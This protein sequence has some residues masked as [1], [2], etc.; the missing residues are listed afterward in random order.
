[1][2]SAIPKSQSKKPAQTR[3]DNIFFHPKRR[4]FLVTKNFTPG[5]SIFGEALLRIGKEEYREWD[6]SRSKLAAGIMNRISQIAVRQGSKVLYLG[7]SHGYT[8]S[9]VSDIVGKEGFVF[10]VE[11][12]PTVAKQLVR[13]CRLRENMAPL[14]E[15]ANHPER[16]A[17]RVVV[18]DVLYQ[19]VAQRNQVEIFRKNLSL[20]IREGGFG[21]LAVK[22]R[23][24]DVTKKPRAV[25]AEVARQLEAF[26]TVVDWRTL[27][28]FEK[29]H[30]L[31]VCKRR[32]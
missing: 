19:D 9:F 27:E 4:S 2:S 24:I 29:D 13:V 1:M 30:A 16:Y 6:P 22:S 3:F 15:D 32:Q 5:R 31:F 28:P 26:C 7:A 25:F 21:L 10:C 18:C 8:P 23:S 11:F 20:L 12:A 17:G 14:L